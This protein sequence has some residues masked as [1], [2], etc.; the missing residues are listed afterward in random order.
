MIR[1]GVLGAKGR[2]GS[3]VCNAV[4]EAADMELVASLDIGD[5]LAR[6]VES[7]RRP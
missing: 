1:V 4:D 5:D 2:M 7:F 3:E 6:L